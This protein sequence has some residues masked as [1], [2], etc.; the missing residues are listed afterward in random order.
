MPPKKPTNKSQTTARSAG[1]MKDKPVPGRSTSKIIFNPK[2]N[3]I[4]WYIGLAIILIL[5]VVIRINFLEIP[6]ERDEGAYVY[7]GKIIL[8]GAIPYIDIGSQRLDGVFYAY[9]VIVA[10]F[11]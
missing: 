7:S 8:N 5:I 11:G 9:A 4:G 1:K 3:A 6:F 10:I 2:N